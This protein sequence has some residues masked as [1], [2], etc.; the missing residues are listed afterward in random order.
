M[1]DPA[2]ARLNRVRRLIRLPRAEPT[3]L[4]SDSNDTWRLGDTILRICWRGDLDRFQREAAVTAV[5]PPQVRAPHL[6]DT[7]R[8]GDLAWQLTRAID[9]EPLQAVWGTLTPSRRDDA[10]AQL[11]TCLA[12]LHAFPLPAAVRALLGVPRPGPDPTPSEVIGSDINPLPYARLV[13]L[14]APARAL[15]GGDPGIIDALTDRLR[16]LARHDPFDAGQQRNG[17]IHGDVHL[18]NALWHEGSVSLLDFEWVR[19]GPPDADLEALLR[20]GPDGL[21]LTPDLDTVL[22]RL[23]EAYPALVS[24]PDLVPR[25]WLSQLAFALRRTLTDAGNPAAAF[26]ALRR[27]L[28]GPDVVRSALKIAG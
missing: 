21:P 25:L 27:L 7:G 28:D 5:L 18:G 23:A 3:R 14:L 24:V 10:I 2:D 15:P 17:C 11:G 20:T 9:G 13:R 22:A 19:L 26:A 12:A 8:A 1:T 16:D 4:P 6:L